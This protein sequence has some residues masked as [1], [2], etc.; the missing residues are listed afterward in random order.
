LTIFSKGIGG[1]WGF[2]VIFGSGGIMGGYKLSATN[3]VIGSLN[4]CVGG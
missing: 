4:G 2:M 3:G 1:I